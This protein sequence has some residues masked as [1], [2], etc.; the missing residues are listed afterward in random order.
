MDS[1][2]LARFLGKTKRSPSGCWLWRGAA[3]RDYGTLW[4]NG[5]LEKAHRLSYEHFN[6][7]IPD[8]MMVDH[9]CTTRMCVNPSHLEIVTNS[10]NQLRANQRR[11]EAAERTE[12]ALGAESTVST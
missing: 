6:G 1:R 4:V 3:T 5:R 2:T 8:G 9:V 10:S 12:P 7:P 11:K